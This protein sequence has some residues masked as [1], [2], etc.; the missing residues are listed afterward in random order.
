MEI[1]Y[2]PYTYEL[3]EDGGTLYIFK[4]DFEVLYEV[5]FKPTPYLFLAEKPFSDDTYEF[6]IIVIEN[7]NHASPPFDNRIGSTIARIFDSFYQDYGNTISLY[8]CA[9]HDNR[10]LVRYRKFNSWFTTFQKSRYYKIDSPIIDS[11]G[12]EFPISIILRA[13]NPYREEIVNSFF[14]VVSKYNK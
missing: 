12:R 9:S 1:D 14:D 6:S 11:E 3:I 7:P 5:R 13:D 8:I 4:T 10:Q 2:S